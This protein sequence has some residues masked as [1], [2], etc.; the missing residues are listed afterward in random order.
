MEGVGV[1]LEEDGTD[2]TFRIEQEAKEG[3]R[4]GNGGCQSNPKVRIGSHGEMVDQLDKT[5]RYPDCCRHPGD[6]TQNP[7]GIQSAPRS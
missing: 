5:G 3:R 2:H 4:D 7:G 6:E 1:T